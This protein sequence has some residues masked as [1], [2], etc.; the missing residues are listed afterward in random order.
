MGECVGDSGGGVAGA[1][2]SHAGLATMKESDVARRA[3]ALKEGSR[4]ESGNGVQARRMRCEG[5]RQW[6]RSRDP[7]TLSI[8]SRGDGDGEEAQRQCDAMRCDAMRNAER[9]TVRCCR[10][11]RGDG[12]WWSEKRRCRRAAGS[13]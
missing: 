13:R 6:R 4:G 8:V 12:S 3:W 9:C 1:A 10:V 2:E 11:R 7:L 5:T